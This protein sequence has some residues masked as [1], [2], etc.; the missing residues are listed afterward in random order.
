MS[1]ETLSL[2]SAAPADAKL[3][4]KILAIGKA[5]ILVTE[6]LIANGIPGEA[7]VAID[8]DPQS[9][10][11][12]SA[13][14]K[15]LLECKCAA[16]PADE[17]PVDAGAAAAKQAA[18]VK[19][20]CQGAGAVFVVAGLGGA[21]GGSAAPVLARVAREAGALVLAF[22][23][24]PFACEGSRRQQSAQRGLEQLKG[25]A[26][27]LICL[28]NEKVLKIVDENTSVLD[29]FKTSNDLLAE[30]VRGLW[31]LLGHKGLLEIHAADLCELV[32][33]RHTES[34]FAAAE[35]MGPTRSR[36][37]VDRLLAHPMLEDGKCLAHSSAVLVSFLGGPDLTMAEVNRIVAEIN[38]HCEHAELLVGA[39]IDESF[40]ERLS[41]TLIV[42]ADERP[43]PGNHVCRA[44]RDGLDNQLL[45]GCSTEARAASR[46][47]PPAPTLSRETV[48]QM[49]SRQKTPGAHS[50]RMPGRLRQAQLPLE[51]VSKGRFDKSEPTI[52]KGED[53]DVPTYLR[54][55]VVLN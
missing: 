47:V 3:Q 49:L 36:D 44:G 31:L 9:L 7:C 34:S 21:A 55:G 37:V 50:R 8:T 27:G 23:L 2:A 32:R 42:N 20:L 41:V 35:A 22:G 28:A 10:G 11:A 45:S 46:L 29:T 13:R 6:K 33:G 51:I 12:S 24:F 39:A 25:V 38:A 14:E 40:R 48:E 5:G 43:G 26:D 54:R 18:R 19:A 30:A 4:I 1:T 52:H 53:L 16:A 15:V 17:Q